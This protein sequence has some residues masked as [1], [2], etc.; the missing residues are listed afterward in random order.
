MVKRT[1]LEVAS[2]IEAF[3]EGT[4]R[5]WDWDDFCSLKIENRDLDAVRLKCRGLS[6]SHPPRVKGH[7]CNEE[8]IGLLREIVRNLRS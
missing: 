8:G 4:G 6:F 2:I 1:D 3:V 5:D 7:Y